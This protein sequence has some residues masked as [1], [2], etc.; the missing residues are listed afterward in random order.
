MTAG[1]SPLFGG[2]AKT[3]E[4]TR[5]APASSGGVRAAAPMAMLRSASVGFDRE[6]AQGS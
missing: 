1:R 4:G 6:A 3:A 2:K 5:Q